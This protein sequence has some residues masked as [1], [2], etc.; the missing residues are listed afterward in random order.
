MGKDPRETAL[1]CESVRHG[2]EEQ[3]MGPRACVLSL[4]GVAAGLYERPA[5]RA[6]LRRLRTA[7]HQVS[8]ASRRRTCL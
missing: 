6:R 4:D 7:D 1:L 3:L 2:L 8:A 5:A